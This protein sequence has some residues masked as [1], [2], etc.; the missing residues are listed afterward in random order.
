[1]RQLTFSDGTT[2]TLQPD[3]TWKTASGRKILLEFNTQDAL[4][5]YSPTMG[6]PLDYA[7]VEVGR[8]LEAEVTNTE[9]VGREQADCVI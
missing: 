9:P 7:L 8:R 2:A 1:M 6:R 3:G 4:E 5:T